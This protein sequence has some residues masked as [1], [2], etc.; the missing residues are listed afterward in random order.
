MK[1]LS[2]ALIILSSSGFSEPVHPVIVPQS[3]LMQASLPLTEEDEMIIVERLIHTTEDQL[4]LHHHLKE[5]MIQFKQYREAFIQGDHS[6]K[7]ASSMVRSARQIL[8]IITTQHLEFHF[9]KDYLDELTVFSSI[10]G[11]NGIKRP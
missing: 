10:A 2:L 5:L 11:K 9:S 4:K 3:S 8:D 1:H 7:N 6:K